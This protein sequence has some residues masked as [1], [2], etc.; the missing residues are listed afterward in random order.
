M[1]EMIRGLVDSGSDP[2]EIAG[3]VLDGIRENRFYILT[4]PEMAGGVTA[5]HEDILSGG[6]PRAILG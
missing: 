3:Q 1:T 5:R 6:P 4:H 2:A